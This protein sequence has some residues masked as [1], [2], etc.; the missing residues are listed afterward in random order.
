VLGALATRSI[1][2]KI[3]LRDRPVACT[4]GRALE[5]LLPSSLWRSC[6]EVL[7]FNVGPAADSRPGAKPAATLLKRTK[8]AQPE[9]TP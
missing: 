2:W 8:G 4:G 9:V 1:A 6:A 3:G 7:G 5:T